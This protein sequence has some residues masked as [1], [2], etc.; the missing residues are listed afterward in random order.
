[1]KIVSSAA[2][3]LLAALHAASFDEAWSATDF[4]TLLASPGVFARLAVEGEAPLGFIL[5]RTAADEAEILTLAI[6][7]AHRRKGGGRALVEA[8]AEVASAAGAETM[9]LEVAE[10]NA[11]A[12]SLYETCGFRTSGRRAGYYARGATR[13]DALALRRDLNRPSGGQYA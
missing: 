11:P 1:M 4:A 9:F 2:G 7:P 6:N 10:D 13:I 5:A 8:A 12:L 3:D